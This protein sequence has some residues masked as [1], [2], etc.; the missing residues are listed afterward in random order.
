MIKTFIL[1]VSTPNK[2]VLIN[3]KISFDLNLRV[4]ENVAYL[5]TNGEETISI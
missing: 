1:G 2:I 5:L 4:D 3:T